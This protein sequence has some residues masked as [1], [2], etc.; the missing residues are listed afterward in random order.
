[1]IAPLVALLVAPAFAGGCDSKSLTKAVNEATPGGM[2]D[3]F[4]NLVACDKAAA[5]AAAP[6]AFAKII[7]GPAAEKAVTAALQVGAQPA[8]RTWITSMTPDEKSAYVNTLGRSCD[9]PDIAA[10]F[11]DTAKNDQEHFWSD[12]YY[13]GLDECRTPEAAALLESFLAAPNSDR[14]RYESLLSAY[15]RNL[16]GKAIPKLSEWLKAQQDPYVAT[17]LVRGFAD[18]VGVGTTSGADP[19]AAKAATAAIVEL[20]PGMPAQAIEGARATLQSIGSDAEADNLVVQ[21]YRDRAQA[22]KLT[23]GMY[24]VKAATC[25]KGDV[26]VEIHT[27]SVVDAGRTW[28]DTLASRV[29]PLV[30]KIS[31]SLPKDCTGTA[32]LTVPLEPFKSTADFDAWIKEQDKALMK[33]YPDSK[34]KVFADAPAAI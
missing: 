20:A 28:P 3:A 14:S 24:V 25:K 31:W 5:K 4:M 30:D 12:R 26:K 19:E 33:K 7:P 23:Y 16:G 8:V 6:A 21:R 11:T 29:Q 22:G 10:F 1:M 2:V 13:A 32:E 18:A 27:A 34:S 15:A 9:Q 17:F